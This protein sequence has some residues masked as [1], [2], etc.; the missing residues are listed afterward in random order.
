VIA[1]WPTNDRGDVDLTTAHAWTREQ[2]AAYAEAEDREWA[3]TV[4]LGA[5]GLLEG[6]E[7]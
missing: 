3:E 6:Q 7:D 5:A 2:R 1:P 4:P